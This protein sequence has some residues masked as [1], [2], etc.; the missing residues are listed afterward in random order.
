M[1][2]TFTFRRLLVLSVLSL[3]FDA[4]VCSGE[5]CNPQ[6]TPASG[7]AEAVMSEK[8]LKEWVKGRGLAATVDADGHI[9]EIGWPENQNPFSVR[10]SPVPI[11]RAV[12]AGMAA[13]SYLRKLDLHN[14]AL[15]D[16]H[17]TRVH[18][19]ESL[20]EVDLDDIGENALYALRGSQ[21][22]RRLSFSSTRE[23][24]RGL[25]ALPPNSLKE[26]VLTGPRLCDN[27][28]KAVARFRN[29]KKLYIASPIISNNGIMALKE[30]HSLRRVTFADCTLVDGDGVANL[31][32]HLPQC[33][34]GYT[35]S[36]PPSWQTNDG[37]ELGKE[38]GVRKKMG[39][40]TMDGRVDAKKD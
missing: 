20:E 32:R 11:N 28:L 6:V 29:L 21:K 31:G 16:E 5:Q 4:A 8:Q 13:L 40:K 10:E 17:F 15:N 18:G 3:S 24:T 33:S 35:E 37:K 36:Y 27:D 39:P 9:V 12:V 22:L 25:Q 2:L 26:L 34:F 30:L 1:E 23:I 7:P 14:E 38:M 19:F